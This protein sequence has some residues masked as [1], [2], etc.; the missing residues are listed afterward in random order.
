MGWEKDR[1]EKEMRDGTKDIMENAQRT[2]RKYYENGFQEKIQYWAQM[3]NGAV[4]KK[5]NKSIV[6]CKEKL[7]YFVARQL[8]ILHL[9]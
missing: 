5:D 8:S 3:L 1:A 9:R 6:R 4:E 2:S 7:D